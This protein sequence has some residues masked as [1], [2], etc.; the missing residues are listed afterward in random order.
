M[1]QWKTI[2]KD[3]SLAQCGLCFRKRKDRFLPQ[4]WETWVQ[5]R[6]GNY[7]Y[8]TWLCPSVNHEEGLFLAQDLYFLAE[9]SVQTLSCFACLFATQFQL[10]VR[11]L[12]KAGFSFPVASSGNLHSFNK[13]SYIN[14]SMFMSQRYAKVKKVNVSALSP[15]KEASNF[16]T[17]I[18]AA[19]KRTWFLCNPN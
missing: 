16:C 11:S 2:K 17:V 8:R 10:S 13:I 3:Y 4:T 19:Q 18:Q 1:S 9:L 6:S 15:G 14:F 5:Q 12:E 7:E